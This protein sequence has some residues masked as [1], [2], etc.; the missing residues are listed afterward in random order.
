MKARSEAMPIRLEA[1]GAQ[2]RPVLYYAL[3][4]VTGDVGAS[5]A[6]DVDAAL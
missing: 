4:D 3:H 2:A 1:R 6:R 5:R